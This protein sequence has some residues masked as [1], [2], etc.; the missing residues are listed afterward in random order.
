MLWAGLTMGFFLTSWVIGLGTVQWV[1]D[2]TN[3][4]LPTTIF[5]SCS[6]IVAHVFVGMADGSMC[7]LGQLAVHSPVTWKRRHIGRSVFAT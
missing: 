3:Q 5:D 4:L 1:V 2:R 7:A 6:L